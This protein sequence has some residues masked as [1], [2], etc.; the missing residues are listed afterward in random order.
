MGARGFTVARRQQR[1]GQHDARAD[2][3]CV[4]AHGLLRQ[5][6]GGAQVLLL[7]R[8]Q[9]R[10]HGELVRAGGGR[11]VARALVV[12]ARTDQIARQAKRVGQ[13]HTRGHGVGRL[14][15][16]VFRLVARFLR[17]VAGHVPEPGRL[18]QPRGVF[19]RIGHQ[20]LRVELVQ[21]RLEAVAAR[22]HGE[23]ARVTLGHRRGADHLVDA[24]PVA[25]GVVAAQ[26]LLGLF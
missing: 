1:A 7:R 6:H 4:G 23:H 19:A 16:R 11:Q 5:L 22:Q 3:P 8:G 10:S 26:Q 15:H 25:V 12:P 17:R 18:G 24:L 20:I 21:L 2:E 14:A 13:G 9:Q